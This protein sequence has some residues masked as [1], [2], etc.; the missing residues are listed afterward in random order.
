LIVHH[1]TV[2]V[3]VVFTVAVPLVP[4]IVIG[5]VPGVAPADTVRV[6]FDL[7][8]PVTEVGLKLPVTPIG[9]PVTDSVT[10]E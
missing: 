9:R 7:P 5:Y 6:R 4:V 10:V 2:K 1:S 3:R 8:E